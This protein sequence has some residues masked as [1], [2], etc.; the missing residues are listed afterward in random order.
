M[1]EDTD[2]PIVLNLEAAMRLQQPPARVLNSLIM[3][4]IMMMK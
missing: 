3:R 1:M 4:A 2:S